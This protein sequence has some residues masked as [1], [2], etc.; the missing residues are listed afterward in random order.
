MTPQNQIASN[1][2]VAQ[3]A[4]ENLHRLLT[5]SATDA[6]FRKQ[7]ISSP[8]QAVADFYG[9]DL[10]EIPESLN[11][12][13]VENTA[14]ATIVLPD[15]VDPEAELSDSELQAVAGGLTP[16]LPLASAVLG[17]AAS[18]IWAGREV[19]KLGDDNAWF[20]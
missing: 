2:D 6:D 15:A 13:F 9:R 8:R 7:L 12:V 20:S 5:R 19:L 3:T 10:S 1:A 11:V 4:Q 18:A 16:L 17:V 14:D